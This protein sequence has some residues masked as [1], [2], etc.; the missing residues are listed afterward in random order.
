MIFLCR[1]GCAGVIL[2]CAIAAIASAWPGLLSEATLLGF[3]LVLV[4]IMSSWLWGPPLLFSLWIVWRRWPPRTHFWPRKLLITALGSLLLSAA[5]VASRWPAR[6]GFHLH[7]A[8]FD[9][10]RLSLDLDAAPRLVDRP[11]GM[12]Y[13]RYAAADPRG[14]TYFQTRSMGTLG[15]D[16]VSFGFAH[17]PNREGS[18]FGQ[19]GYRLNSMGGDWYLFMASNDW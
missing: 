11:V 12:Y 15:P 17:R 1:C 8:A 9:Q 6:L 5:L 2:G 16:S 14:G 7:R 4:A 3:I 10:A 18:P 13:I 19:A